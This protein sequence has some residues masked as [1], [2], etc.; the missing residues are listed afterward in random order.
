MGLPSYE[1]LEHKF[2]EYIGVKDAV[3]A[4]TG[5]AALHLAIEAKQYPIGTEIIVPDFTMIATAWAVTYAG[6]TPVF[7]GCS[8]Y[9]YNID[10][11]AI[12]ECITWKTK[13]IMVT[14]IYGRISPMA[15]LHSLCEKHNL[16]LIED[17]AEAH[18]AVYWDGPFSGKMV[19]SAGIG[20]FSFFKNKIIAGEEG[21]MVTVRDDPEYAK[22][23]RSMKNMAFTPEHNYVHETKGFNYRMTDSQAKL[24]LH[25][26][27]DVEFNIQERFRVAKTYDERLPSEIQKEARRH[28]VW[29]YDIVTEDPKGLVEFLNGHGVAARRFFSPMSSQPSLSM[30][31]KA[32]YP[33]NGIEAHE[34][35]CYLPVTPLM[36]KDEIWSICI[37]VESFLSQKKS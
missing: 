21:G 4:N 11:A 17:C 19:G 27:D 30:G 26:L 23:L 24:I 13:A 29:V 8:N 9:D 16:D 33:R 35:G 5:T 22:R 32:K 31:R 36:T 6:H 37:L 1:R 20:C 14:H 28:A 3:T 12:E 10:L 18:G 2:A 25:S 34:F 15:F 7:V